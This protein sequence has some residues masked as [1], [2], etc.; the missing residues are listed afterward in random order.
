MNNI[1]IYT[2]GSFP[3]GGAAENFVR[4]LAL[5][6]RE[7]EQSVSVKLFRGG[8]TNDNDTGIKAESV[9]FRDRTTNEFFKVFELFLLNL[10]IPYFLWQ[11]KRN[12][13]A[14][15]I[16]LY[17]IDYFYYVFPFMIWSKVFNIKLIRIVPDKYSKA[18]I[19]PV[20]WKFPKYYFFN[21]QLSYFDR[22]MD[23]IVF[24]STYL[25]NEYVKSGG[26]VD[27]AIIIPHFIDIDQFKE[28]REWNDQELVLA[29]SGSILR[30]NG[31]FDL[32]DAFSLLLEKKP[33]LKLMMLGNTMNLDEE[34]RK[35]YDTLICN[36]GDRIFFNG[37]VPYQDVAK[38]LQKVSILI[39]PRREGEWADAGFPTKLG[40]YF[41]CE[42]IVVSTEVG[43]VSK[44]FT[45]GNELFISRP[46]DPISLAEKI[47]FIIDHLEE[48]KI[49]GTNGLDW[50]N[51]NLHYKNSARKLLCFLQNE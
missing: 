20:W 15:I 38:K 49:V 48:Y 17:G 21:L 18:T 33:Y 31:I 27:R 29:Y 16:L 40:E 8:S 35:L 13:K 46:N 6:L 23:G 43:D 14:N 2:S 41:A 11:D 10:L 4:L 51:R 37:S 9:L 22:F 50:A 32:L 19:V 28:S 42:K 26:K 25:Y 5:G 12:N 45:D 30:N 7:N 3:Y 39:N 36:L 34:D 24:L 1:I 47:D 44:Y